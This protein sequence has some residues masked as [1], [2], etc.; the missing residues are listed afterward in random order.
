[1]V[2]RDNRTSRRTIV[3]ISGLSGERPEIREFSCNSKTGPSIFRAHGRVRRRI[4]SYHD[5][6]AAVRVRGALCA[7]CSQSINHRRSWTRRFEAR[8]SIVNFFPFYPIESSETAEIRFGP[9]KPARRRS[10]ASGIYFYLYTNARRRYRTA[11]V[12]G[13]FGRHVRRDRHSAD[14]KLETDDGLAIESSR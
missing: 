10:G 3:K 8:F 12:T 2:S 13:E 5:G 1:M 4:A 9:Q 14:E 11:E 7:G 6:R